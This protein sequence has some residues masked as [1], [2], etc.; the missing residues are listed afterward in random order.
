MGQEMR[1]Y[2]TRTMAAL[3]A[4]L[5]VGAARADITYEA[6]AGVGHSDNVTRTEDAEVDDTLAS[7]GLNLNWRERT[8]RLQ[9]D[10]VTDVSYIEYLDDT[11]DAEVVGNAD[12]NLVFGIVPETFTWQLQ[13][14]FGQARTNPF[15][16]VT[17]DNRENINYFTTGPDVRFRLGSQTSLQ[18]YGRYSSTDYEESPLD[19]ER[20]S[21]GLGLFRDLSAA[22][23]VGINAVNDESEFDDPATPGYERRSTY[24]SYDLTAG[25]TRVAAQVGYSQIEIDGQEGDGGALVNIRVARDLSAS[26]SITVSASRQFTDAGEALGGMAGGGEF[27][28]GGGGGGPGGGGELTA[29]AGPYEGSDYSVRW[30]FA[31]RRTAL[32]L[33]VD[34]SESKYEIQPLLNRKSHA[35]YGTFSRQLRPTL[36]LQLE[37]NVRNEDFASATFEAEDLESSLNLDWQMA[38]RFGLRLRAER[39]DHDTNSGIGEYVENRLFLYLTYLGGAGGGNAAAGR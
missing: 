35:Y 34:Y 32:S 8:R 10:V 36:R 11:Y 28:G 14:S 24:L 21:V 12:A 15:E 30:Q 19:S 1:S 38:R 3:G 39:Y 23:R 2:M 22:S 4:L 16:P 18:V 17:P 20:T 26:S 29:S 25:R 13:D 5:A 37:V 31:K 6:E 7:L 27:G 33:G 9:G